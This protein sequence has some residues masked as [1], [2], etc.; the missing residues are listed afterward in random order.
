MDYDP[1]LLLSPSDEDPENDADKMSLDDD[2]DHASLCSSSECPDDALRDDGDELGDVT[3]EEDWASI[4]AAALRQASLS[5]K[6]IPRD[7]SAYSKCR[8]GGG[9]GGG[10]PPREALTTSMPGFGIQP[11]P[12]ALSL[13]QSP[14][15]QLQRWTGF[16]ELMQAVGN[17][18][19]EREAIEALVR[20]SSV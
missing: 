15:G 20:L 11:A 6:S 5:T 2:D 14:Q 13:P 19:Q 17:D 9:G 16:G 12:S 7:A 10:G 4:G 18:S 3:D 1:P 8:L